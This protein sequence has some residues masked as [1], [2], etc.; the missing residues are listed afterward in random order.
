MV[1]RLDRSPLWLVPGLAALALFAAL[2]A[3]VET[4]AAGR[5]FAANGGVYIAASL[6]W[7]W[8]VE[9]LRP[10]RWDPAG[11][12][13]RLA[14]AMVIVPAPRR[15]P[16]ST[17]LP[18]RSVGR[19][20][21]P[22]RRLPIPRRHPAARPR[23]LAQTEPSGSCN[24]R[25]PLQIEVPRSSRGTTAR[26]RHCRDGQSPRPPDAPGPARPLSP[27]RPHRL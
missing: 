27:G 5:A 8:A 26:G 24:R 17:G 14:G 16:V 15:R 9:G 1:L 22:R 21:R 10:D 2:L 4:E 7:L 23:D 11:A 25:R 19:R 6:G 20:R 3:R 12:A 18:L 13:L